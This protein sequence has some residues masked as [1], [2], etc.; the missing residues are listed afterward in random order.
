MIDSRSLY[1]NQILNHYSIP[2]LEDKSLYS[3]QWTYDGNKQHSRLLSHNEGLD[4]VKRY[5]KDLEQKVNELQYVEKIIQVV[6]E[7]NNEI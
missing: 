1:I 7:N 5:I 6:K 4:V 2:Y 3:V